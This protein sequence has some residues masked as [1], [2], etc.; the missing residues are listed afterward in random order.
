M[1]CVLPEARFPG[2]LTSAEIRDVNVSAESRVVGQVPA[3]VVGI[4]VDHDLIGIPEP[5][6]GEVVFE[7]GHAEV[8]T[9]KPEALP[10]ST[11]DPKDVAAAETAGKASMLPRM[12]NVEADII[13]A[14][15]VSDPL[16][17]RVDVGSLR[18]S[19]LV[20]ER[21]G[22]LGPIFWRTVFRGAVLLLGLGRSG[23][24]SGNVS[25]TDVTRWALLASPLLLRKSG[26]QKR[27]K[28]M[29]EARQEFSCLPPVKR[30]GFF[31]NPGAG[32]FPAKGREGFGC[33]CYIKRG[34]A[35]KSYSQDI[36]G[37]G[38]PCS[39]LI[40]LIRREVP[41]YRP[42]EARKART[43]AGASWCWASTA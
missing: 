8:E 24:T 38:T 23:T 2:L 15:I 41:A 42:L 16:I 43:T 35:A 13:A 26:G 19:G 10:V 29:Q 39:S 1:R 17:T 11:R 33:P 36:V 9:S 7:W 25:T 21:A 6:I 5:V 34:R 31:S 28:T 27:S 14:G 18:V 20:A 37:E 12:I 3:V 32:R 4:F 22:F 30:Y 40:P